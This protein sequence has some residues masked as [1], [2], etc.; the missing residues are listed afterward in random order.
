[1]S[2]AEGTF[3]DELGP[4]ARGEA[5]LL[6]QDVIAAPGRYTDLER[7][8]ARQVSTVLDAIDL[9]GDVRGAVCGLTYGAAAWTVQKL[10]EMCL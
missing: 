7:S 2:V 6:L 3:W 5:W 10:E 1:M 8:Y 4:E 9:G